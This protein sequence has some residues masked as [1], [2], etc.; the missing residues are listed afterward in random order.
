MSDL[1]SV[2]LPAYNAEKTLAEAVTSTLNQTHKDLE[3]ILIDDGS[4]DGTLALARDLAKIDPRIRVYARHHEGLPAALNYGLSQARGAWIARM[5]A[6]DIMLPRRLKAQLEYIRNSCRPNETI[7]GSQV[8]IFSETQDNPGWSRYQSWLNGLINAQEHRT[9]IFI[10]APIAHPTYFANK[11]VFKRLKGYRQGPFTEDYD[12]LLRADETGINL[13]KVP[14]ILL[15][16]R[17]HEQRLT[18]TSETLSEQGLR[19]LKVQH[20]RRRHQN[21]SLGANR[22]WTIWG[23]GPKGKR[24]LKLLLEAG[25]P[26]VAA[27]DIAKNKHGRSLRGGKIPVHEVS[28]L[29]QHSAR[30]FVL[31]TVATQG[32]R[33]IQREHLTKLGW[34]EG[35]DFLAV[36]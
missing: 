20:L 35:L 5:D 31:L 28:W 21:T 9:D 34:V 27:V 26:V 33:K 18:H 2:I 3:V 16:W 4:Q 11:D 7:L 17:E 24:W 29:E 23:V 19:R 30:P 22:A 32:A 6:D 10:D 13:E 12:L 14:E 25:L 8:E 36:Q 1:I 15:R